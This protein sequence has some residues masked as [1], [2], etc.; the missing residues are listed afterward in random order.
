MPL[1]CINS[2]ETQPNDV[3]NLAR[4]FSSHVD[5]SQE[6]DGRDGDQDVPTGV[7]GRENQYGPRT[8]GRRENI[9][10]QIYRS[11]EEIKAILASVS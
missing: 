5:L 8:Y 7:H 3:S 4:D 2:S 9:Y 6:W 11:Q 1:V 10:M